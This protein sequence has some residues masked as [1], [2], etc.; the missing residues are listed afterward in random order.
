MQADMMLQVVRTRHYPTQTDAIT[1]N[2]L[3]IPMYEP[4]NRILLQ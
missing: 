2:Y 4:N 3:R 1:I